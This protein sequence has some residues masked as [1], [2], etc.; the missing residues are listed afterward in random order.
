VVGAVLG[1]NA[2]EARG[3]SSDSMVEHMSM[4][5]FIWARSA[6]SSALVSLLAEAGAAGGRWL[7]AGTEPSTEEESESVD[8]A[9][10]GGRRMRLWLSWAGVE[11]VAGVV[12]AGRVSA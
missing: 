9:G 6:T 10:E 3:N 2:E 5:L 7:G 4:R 11:A 12:A 8:D 1:V